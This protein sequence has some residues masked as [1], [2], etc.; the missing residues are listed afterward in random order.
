MAITIPPLD[1]I[2]GRLGKLNQEQLRTL[3][4]Y[5]GVPF[6]TLTKIQYGTTKNPGIETVRRFFPLLSV[7]AGDEGDQDAG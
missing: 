1:L 5:S 6:G 2:R 7:M 4:E 3:S